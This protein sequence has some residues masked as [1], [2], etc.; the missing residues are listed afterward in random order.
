[1]GYTK[2]TF[3]D[4]ETVVKAENFNHIEDGI[5]A[6]ETV[7]NNALTTAE[8]KQDILVSGTSIKTINEQSLLGEGNIN[9]VGTINGGNTSKL[10]GKKVMFFGDSITAND[11]F[12]RNELSTLTGINTEACFA[13]SGATIRHGEGNTLDGVPVYGTNNTVPNQVQKLINNVSNYNTPDIIVVAASTNDIITKEQVNNYDETQFTSNDYNY[14]DVDDCDLASFSGAIRWIYE[15]IRSIYP[16]TLVV[17]CTPIQSRNDG[18]SYVLQKIKRDVIISICDRMAVPY[19]DAFTKSGIYGQ[20][21]VRGANGKYLKDGIH[22]NAEGAKILAKCYARELEYLLSMDEVNGDTGG[23]TG[24]DTLDIV[25]IP[26]TNETPGNYAVVA[27]NGAYTI[28]KF[29]PTTNEGDGEVP[30]EYCSLAS[31]LYDLEEGASVAMT[32]EQTGT[33]SAGGCVE[34]FVLDATHVLLFK[35]TKSTGTLK[36]KFSTGNSTAPFAL[37]NTSANGLIM[38]KAFFQQYAYAGEYVIDST[39]D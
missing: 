30:W 7:A 4:L 31:S 12:Y 8:S 22:P 29:T 2:Q 24:G 6:V 19:I 21:E 15:K 23:D 36:L 5:I 37:L 32:V 25:T 13:I 33:V 1:M 14:I 38:K 27:K 35:N 9:I 28:E 16:N 11:D 3:I 39:A 34:K 26:A 20:F 17:F 10:K 18:R